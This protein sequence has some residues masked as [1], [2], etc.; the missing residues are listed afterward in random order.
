MSDANAWLPE[1]DDANRPFFDGARE[2]KLRL[3]RCEACGGWMYPVRKRCQH[4]G[5][6]KL[7]WADA[8][9]R[10]TL[11]AHG[12]LQREYHPRHR[13]R[14][15]VILAQVDLEEGVRMNTNLVGVAPADARV[16]MKLRVAFERSPA[17]E[18]IP[19]FE[20]ARG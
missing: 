16:G 18:A 1:P 8:S 10:G 6:P 2:G 3:Q 9:G 19:V 11:Y 5:S 17:G 13:G 15:P 12:Q 14:L 20:P 4:C 7:A